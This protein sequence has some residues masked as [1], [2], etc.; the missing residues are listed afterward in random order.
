[1]VQSSH[2]LLTELH[3]AQHFCRLSRRG[4]SLPRA[5]VPR[6][7]QPIFCTDYMRCVLRHPAFLTSSKLHLVAR[8]ALV[9]A[10]LARSSV[11]H[12]SDHNCT[13]RL[14]ASSRAFRTLQA[15][16]ADAADMNDWPCKLSALELARVFVKDVASKGGKVLL[17]PD[18]DA[19]G[20]CAGR[21]QHRKCI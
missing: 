18:R 13:P 17:A 8:V 2:H 15:L 14:V 21:L 20:L 12:L 10:T 7:V 3:V 4:M 6:H 16:H 9:R 19:D 11:K 5:T 1:M